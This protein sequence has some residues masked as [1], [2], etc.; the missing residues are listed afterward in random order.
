MNTPISLDLLMDAACECL[1][2]AQMDA[3]E[4][5][6]KAGDT[7]ERLSRCIAKR[8]FIPPCSEER[9]CT[10]CF[11]GNGPCERPGWTVCA[12]PAPSPVSGADERDAKITA[13]A[14]MIRGI[15]MTK[16]QDAWLDAIKRRIQFMLAALAPTP[17]VTVNAEHVPDELVGNPHAGGTTAYLATEH[18]NEGWNDCRGMM[19]ETLKARAILATA[20]PATADALTFDD[21]KTI[22]RLLIGSGYVATMHRVRAAMQRSGQ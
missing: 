8:V 20:A 6:V 5:V 12:D 4:T 10:A 7:G 18:Y 11:T 3:F 14:L 17:T 21:L 16:P 2:P 9:P 22:E 15:C 1:S 13:C 19:L